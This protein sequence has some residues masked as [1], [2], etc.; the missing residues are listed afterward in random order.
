VIL[1]TAE[2]PANKREARDILLKYIHPD[3][4]QPRKEFDQQGLLDL[5]ASLKSNGQWVEIIVRPFPGKPDHFILIDGER[6]WRASPYAGL[7]CLH[8]IVVDGPLDADELLLVQMSLGLTNAKLNSLDAGAGFLRLMDRLKLDASELA[9]KLGTA[10][11]TISKSLSVFKFIAPELH[12]DVRSFAI[13]FT[14]A[15]QLSRL[16]NMHARQVEIAAA[17]KAN[18]IGRKGVEEAVNK[19][20]GNG[21]KK[22]TPPIEVTEG[23]ALAKFPATWSWDQIVQWVS[24]I[25]EAAKRGA[26]MPGAPTAYLQ[27]LLK[28]A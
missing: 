13:P 25:G 14:V 10:E 15:Y 11:S 24:R 2:R 6:R 21:K 19:E 8:A 22:E 18:V 23:E 20:L 26:K 12:A 17:V 9:E 1:P 4:E 16:K 28:S 3:P 7:D 5:A 27:G